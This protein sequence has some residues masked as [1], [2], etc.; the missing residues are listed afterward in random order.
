MRL[1]FVHQNFPGQYRHLVRHCAS[2]PDCE[3]ACIGESAN[4]TQW[5]GINGVRL[6]GTATPQKGGLSTH[7][8][9][10]DFE[11]HILRGLI[12]ARTAMEIRK[13][14]F[15][16]DV[17][18]AHIGWGEA[19]YLKDIFPEARILAFCEFYFNATGSVMDFE[20]IPLSPDTR[21]N[22]RTC[23]ATQLVSLVAADHGVAPTRWQ[24]SQY[25][26][27]FTENI[28]VVHDGI[29][30]AAIQPDPNAHCTLSPAGVRLKSGDE[31]ITY[32]SRYCEPY[33]GFHILTQALP[34]IQQLRPNAHVVI[35]GKDST[36]YGPPPPEG[37]THRQFFMNQVRDK[38]DSS[39]IHFLGYLPHN[40]VITLLQIS[41]VHIYLTYPF[42]LSWSML[43]AMSAGCLVIGSKT[44][45]VEEVIE[46]GRNGLLVDFFDPESLARTIADVLA[47]PGRMQPLRDAA[48]KTICDNYDLHSISL[49]G[50]M[51]LI[52]SLAR[53]ERPP[54]IL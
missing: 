15:V 32:A 13:S 23:N 39:K 9:V 30:T 47:H 2:M 46:H 42:V 31:V 12:V 3:I 4:M 11:G 54:V 17:I 35:I 21:L 40:Q 52:H 6:H 41:A 8:Y 5:E 16:P 33:R 37:T 36:G 26:P 20:K 34:L 27:M 49:P 22:T 53:G 29:D 50:Q 24:R 14:G 1:L 25:P 43:E 28:S 44:P 51:R 7:P 10:R 18:C 38:L 19:L 48:R 45:P